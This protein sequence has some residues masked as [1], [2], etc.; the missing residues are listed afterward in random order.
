MS[1]N[2]QDVALK[3]NLLY[4]AT[5]TLNGGVE[6]KFAPKWT[7][8]L[9]AN[10]N[11]WTVDNRRWKHWLVQPE[12]RY[13]FCQAFS[14]HFVGAHLLGGQYNFGNLDMDFSL[15]GTDFGTLKDH[16]ISST[17]SPFSSR[18]FRKSRSICRITRKT[19]YKKTSAHAAPN[20][21]SSATASFEGSG[22]GSPS[23]RISIQPTPSAAGI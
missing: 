5:L 21:Q 12:A 6:A 18:L 17:M 23:F 4:D 7:G 3:T 19:P 15:L 20:P 13:W 8:D 14:G 9:S 16:R 1:A 10:L 2:A 22:A 11:A